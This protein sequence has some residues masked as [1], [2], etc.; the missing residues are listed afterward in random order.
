M[1]GY[2]CVPGFAAVMQYLSISKDGS[3]VDFRDA[4]PGR[5]DSRRAAA[6]GAQPSS[7]ADQRVASAR[8]HR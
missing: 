7:G 5:S 8:Q 2:P 4:P 6:G 3:L 1:I